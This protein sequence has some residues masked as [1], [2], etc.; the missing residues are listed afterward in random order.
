[1]VWVYDTPSSLRKQINKLA[2][3]CATR[4][5]NGATRA[6]LVQRAKYIISDLTLR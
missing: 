6:T 1:M 3:T 2:G 4:G 5:K